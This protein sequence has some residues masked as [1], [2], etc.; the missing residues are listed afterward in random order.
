M[1]YMVFS[2]RITC[3]PLLQLWK[4]FR[5]AVESSSVPPATRHVL[6]RLGENNGRCFARVFGA[7]VII[8]RVAEVHSKR[9]SWMLRLNNV[10]TFISSSGSYCEFAQYN[11][12]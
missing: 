6:L 10:A 12:L 1:V 9:K 8:G 2:F 3:P 11:M 7:T 4:A 5:R